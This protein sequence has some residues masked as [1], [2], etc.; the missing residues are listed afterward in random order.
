[1]GFLSRLLRGEKLKSE[2]RG[3]SFSD[4]L[5]ASLNAAGS[6]TTV[7]PGNAMQIATVF[8][9]VRV[10]AES[11]ASLPLLL[12]Q[13]DGRR[14]RLAIDH[15][16]YSLLR[17]LPNPEITSV[18]MRMLA[19]GHLAIWGN[20]Y[21]Q[22]V[23]SRSGRIL[24]LWPMRPDQVSVY[25]QRDGWLWYYYSPDPNADPDVREPDNWYR[26][27]EI[28]HL[29]GLGMDGVMGYSTIRMLAQS[30]MGAVKGANRFVTAFY[31]NGARPGIILK[32][33]GLLGDEAY[34][35]LRDSWEARHQGV[36]R[37]HRVAILEEGMG[38]E[39][40]GVPPQD[41]QMIETLKLKS[42][43]IAAA[44]RVP[45][46][47][48]G[49]LE[50]ATFGNIE[51][52]SLEFVQYTLAPWISVWEQ[53]IHRDL[54]TVEERRSHYAEF[55]VDALLRGDIQSRYAAYQSA[56]TAS[57]STVNEIR[58]REGLDPV[59]GGDELRAPLNMAPVGAGATAP[60][61]S[62][63]RSL[64]VATPR[65]RRADDEAMAEQRQALMRSYVALYEDAA[66]R[67]VRRETADMR[68]AIDKYLRKRTLGDFQE[69][70][71]TFYAELTPVLREALLPI[72]LNF[73]TQMAASVGRELDIDDPAVDDELRRFI[74][75]YLENFAIGHTAISSGQ[76][77]SVI[78]ASLTEGVDTADALDQRLD[79]WEETR[80]G[81]IAM[82]EAFEAGNA[83][84]VAFY[85]AVGVTV[86]RWFARGQSCP[87][88]RKMHGKK[89]GIS[90]FFV[91]AGSTIDDD[92]QGEMTL[93]RNTRHP[94]LH[95]GC[96]CAVLAG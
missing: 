39:E 53:A 57:W 6:G 91:T 1:M 77:T 18:E 14:K 43:E 65:E 54:L 64:L 28:M 35:R 20:A 63:G 16:L 87:F 25:R 27:D 86:L 36:D 31:E 9:C 52:Q 61:G 69:W 59:E 21:I 45:L 66:R 90:G 4:G 75:K 10:L 68:R 58:E 41:A 34:E 95:G 33:P 42:R 92:D 56:L 8:A 88:C 78:E 85:G 2:R 74:D 26:F 81:K 76:I 23:R 12:Y 94:P 60:A 48:I 32:H 29:R 49:D 89:V 80:P 70:L 50:R 7:T 55:M 47:M 19:M 38:V 15:P 30:T 82:Q 17:D 93:S 51:Q 83:L 24:E 22:V 3:V 71:N 37:A 84:A 13:R 5:L 44:F 96:D 79:Q 46:H 72:M 11:L 40:I 67:L 62:A 73:A